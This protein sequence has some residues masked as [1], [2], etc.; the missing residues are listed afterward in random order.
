MQAYA[1]ATG[2]IGFGQSVPEGA[3]PIAN[4]VER[5]LREAIAGTARLSRS[6]DDVFIVPG[7]PEAPNGDAAVDALLAYC[8]VVKSSLKWR[9]ALTRVEGLIKGY[10]GNYEYVVADGVVHTLSETEMLIV[11]DAINGLMV[12]EKILDALCE[13]RHLVKEAR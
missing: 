2:R 1:W 6:G 3:L 7:V 9:A 8:D 11:E 10:L 13:W 12:E 4:G 5:E